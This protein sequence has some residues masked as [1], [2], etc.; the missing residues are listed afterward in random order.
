MKAFGREFPLVCTVGA[1]QEITDLCPDS[2]IKRLGELLTGKTNDAINFEAEFIAA[3]S[4]GAETQ[5][6]FAAQLRGEHYTAQPLT[7]AMIRALSKDEFKAAFAEA[8]RA[9]KGDTAPTVEVAPA[10]KNEDTAEDAALS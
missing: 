9:Y 7:V 6:A 2:D 8:M 10:K 5:A 3:L 1:M 4:R